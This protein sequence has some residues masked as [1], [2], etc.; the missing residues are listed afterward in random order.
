[1]AKRALFAVAGFLGLCLSLS[2]EQIQGTEQ[3][4]LGGSPLDRSS[5]LPPPS[6]SLEDSQRFFF[7]TSFG[8]MQPTT[9]FLPTFNPVQPRTVAPPSTHSRPDSIDDVVDLRSA[10]RIHV[11]GEIGFLYGR[12]SGKYAVEYEQ[13]YVIGELGN[14]KFHLTVGTSY[15]HAS[16]RVPRWGR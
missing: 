16:G 13:G 14:D 2:A 6:L 12:S 9:D 7:S 11:G 1:M 8:W 3:L 10:D 5:S 4:Q 15:E